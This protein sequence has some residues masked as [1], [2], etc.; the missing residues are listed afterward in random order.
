M[1]KELPGPKE[2]SD[3][4]TAE[5]EKAKRLPPD[6]LKALLVPHAETVE[7]VGKSIQQINSALTNWVDTHREKIN[8]F[9]ENVARVSIQFASAIAA[10]SERF[11]AALAKTE[12]LAK[13]GWTFPSQLPLSDLLLLSE[14]EDPAQADAFMLKHYEESDPMFEDME[15]RLLGE[16][17]L[18]SFR[19][20]LPQCFRAM[21]RDDYALTI[22][23]FISMLE[24]II[25]QFNPPA[26]M[27]GDVAKTLKKGGEVARR[28][29][30]DIMCASVWLSLMT[31]ISQ[32]W[33]QYPNAA[34]LK[35]QPM[36]L[37]RNP[38]QHGRM[39]PPNEKIELLRLLNALETS[40]TL[41]EHLP[42]AFSLEPP[43]SRPSETL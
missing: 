21:R 38:I 20:V 34:F 16:P 8:A 39:E 11:D 5:I 7:T 37:A 22:P 41:H 32:L 19:T 33:R 10:A 17:R 4:L 29:K 31:F 28:A 35:E 42:D 18:A 26:L 1:S 30:Q 3:Y 15:Q 14:I 27:A 9:F 43:V 40:L 25:L 13:L 2:M 12:H 24:N 6:E 36:L 23:N